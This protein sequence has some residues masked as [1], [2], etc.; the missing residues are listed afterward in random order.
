MGN[1]AGF[2][3][4]EST[5]LEHTISRALRPPHPRAAETANRVGD[6]G[7]T[8]V[9]DFPLESMVQ[10]IMAQQQRV[11][12]RSTRALSLARPLS[13]SEYELWG[14]P[15]M[16]PRTRLSSISS[17]QLPFFTNAGSTRRFSHDIPANPS[18][19]TT[20]DAPVPFW[21]FF[22]ASS[23]S[24]ITSLSPTV[25]GDGVY[26]YQL[27]HHPDSGSFDSIDTDTTMPGTTLGAPALD[28]VRMA[29]SS[30]TCFANPTFDSAAESTTGLLGTGQS[31]RPQTSKSAWS[32]HSSNLLFARW[33]RRHQ[34]HQL[35]TAADEVGNGCGTRSSDADKRPI[36][37]EDMGLPRRNA[38]FQKR[39]YGMPPQ[40]TRE[41]FEALPLAIQ[42]KVCLLFC[43]AKSATPF[44]SSHLF[45]ALATRSAY[46]FFSFFS[47]FLL[48]PAH[49]ALSRLLQAPKPSQLSSRTPLELPQFC[50]S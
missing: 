49:H 43:L 26:H 34:S 10:W 45:Q 5:K 9:L 11:Q 46:S 47:F 14:S 8:T 18:S 24:S 3:A 28:G 22:R 48:L 7:A 40:L 12:G 6:L 44:S 21:T 2:G 35:D 1:R 13:T 29:S 42:R 4:T 27:D 36:A 30:S 23:T 25:N 39:P 20:A 19:T 17:L 38:S 31:W 33:I 50:I 41:E 37:P 16:S 32:T 15:P